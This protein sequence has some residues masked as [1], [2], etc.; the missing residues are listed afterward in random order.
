MNTT[1]SEE[2]TSILGKY[3]SQKL[4]TY[5]VL[6]LLGGDTVFNDFGGDTED[7]RYMA[8]LN[9]GTFLQF[10]KMDSELKGSPLY[11]LKGA[12]FC[13]Q[14]VCPMCQF[15]R[16]ERTFVE[17]SR[18][19]SHLEEKGFRFLH[20]VLTIPNA[21][22]ALELVEGIKIL[23]KGFS[24]LKLYKPIRGAF[25]GFLRCLEISYNYETD[26]FHPHLHVLVAVRKSYFNDSKAYVSFDLLSELWAKAVRKACSSSSIASYFDP[27]AYEVFSVHLGACRVGD[28]SGVAEVCKYCVKPLNL[29]KGSE[30]QNKR[31]LLTVWYTLK[32]KRFL[33]KYGVIA[34][35]WKLLGCS[36]ELE[37]LQES[38]T[39][40]ACFSWD[41]RQMKY[42]R[43]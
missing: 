14:R 28:H 4:N 6:E 22:T 38:E 36:D 32:G 5:K 7:K 37:E 16:A 42:R 43:V 1:L 26:C 23:F 34:E 39:S 40:T 11:R 30:L 25:K 13:R 35:T 17:A 31:L 12:N 24:L 21:E 8:L 41:V 19:V 10:S 3:E 9:C 18:V 15:R 29:E 2:F 20:M 27:S 33:Q